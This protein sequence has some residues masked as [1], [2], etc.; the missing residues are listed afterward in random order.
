MLRLYLHPRVLA[1]TLRGRHQDELARVPKPPTSPALGAYRE[2]ESLTDLS[3]RDLMM[4]INLAPDQLWL[5]NANLAGADLTHAKLDKADL[6]GANLAGANLAGSSLR[7]A[8][9][10]GANLEGA[11]LEGASL[12][13]AELIRADLRGANLRG[14]DLEGAV[15]GGAYYNSRT[16]WPKNVDPEDL[17]AVLADGRTWPD[18]L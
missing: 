3:K 1:A 10:D 9:L 5:V 6:R 15:T 18:T 17:G 7:G 16:L 4:L 11:N 14:A 8:K 12:D 13:H 2:E